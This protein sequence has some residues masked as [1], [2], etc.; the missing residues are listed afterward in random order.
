MLNPRPH[1]RIIIAHHLVLMG[2]AHWLPNDLRGSGSDTIRNEILKDL[3]DIHP[4]RKR[5]Q[6]DRN[7]LRAFHH[8]AQPLLEQEVIWF[9][10]EMRNE[11]ARAFAAVAANFN[12]KIYACAILRNHAHLV[13]PRHAHRHDI[14]WRTFA[15]AAAQ[16]LRERFNLPARHRIWGNR[17][18]S[19]FLYTPDDVHGRI[20][21]VN[22]NPEKEGLP[23]QHWDFISEYPPRRKR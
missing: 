6:P 12:Y 21:Y 5:I 19:K 7:E 3:G 18:Y 20:V 14:L 4:G 13:V 9:N 23:R 22:D 8:H 2:Y 11:I 15:E 10:Q 17:P 16:Q 1:R